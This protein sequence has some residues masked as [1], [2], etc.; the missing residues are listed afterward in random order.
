M[1]CG[2]LGAPLPWQCREIPF[3]RLKCVYNDTMSVLFV[4]FGSFGAPQRSRSR[5]KSKRER[6]T[7]ALEKLHKLPIERYFTKEEVECWKEPRLRRELKKR[8]IGRG[9]ITKGKSSFKAYSAKREDM[10]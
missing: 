5:L 3:T 7:E 10:A 8:G 9:A 2:A 4:D 1:L 6:K